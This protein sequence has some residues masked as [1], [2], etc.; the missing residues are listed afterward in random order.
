MRSL[1]DLITLTKSNGYQPGAHSEQ[2][3]IL[4]REPV[5]LYGNHTELL[6]DRAIKL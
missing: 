3:G 6:P 2:N 1:N 4:I 5:G